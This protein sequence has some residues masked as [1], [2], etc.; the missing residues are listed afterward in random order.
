MGLNQKFG[1]KLVSTQTNCCH[2]LPS[3]HWKT[4]TRG[5]RRMKCFLGSP[6]RG[7][8]SFT[9]RLLQWGK[10]VGSKLFVEGKKTKERLLFIKLWSEWWN[11]KNSSTR[12]KEVDKHRSWLMPRTEELHQT[13]QN[14]HDRSHRMCKTSY[15][16]SVGC[17]T[18]H[19]TGTDDGSRNFSTRNFSPRGRWWWFKDW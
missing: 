16:L 3:V 8:V 7:D 4:Y 14:L 13:Y 19:C 12:C 2:Y 15:Y 9:L 17:A 10:T 11:G 18:V 6:W 5:Q 1:E